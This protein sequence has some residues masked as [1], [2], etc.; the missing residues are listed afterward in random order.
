M[1]EPL[2]DVIIAGGIKSH[3]EES[4]LAQEI[5][6]QP[7]ASGGIFKVTRAPTEPGKAIWSGII[8]HPEGMISFTK[9]VEIVDQI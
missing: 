4:F 8:V 6:I 9:S 2:G 5:N 1:N 7:L 3:Q